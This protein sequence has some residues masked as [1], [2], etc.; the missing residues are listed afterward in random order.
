MTKFQ[1][2]IPVKENSLRLPRKNVLPFGEGNLLTHKI[3]Q[4]QN[5]AQ[6]DEIIVSTDSDEMARISEAMGC[7]VVM[8]PK[9]YADGSASFS[10]F[11][12]YL[13]SEVVRSGHLVWSCVTS[14]L[15]DEVAMKEALAAYV[16]NVIN[17]DFDSLVTVQSFRHHMFDID[18]PLNFEI[19][20]GHKD[21][22]DLVD[23]RIF[24]NG[25]VIAHTEL[26]KTWGDHFGPHAF[27]HE[28]DQ[29]KSIDIDT[30]VDYQIAVALF[31]KFFGD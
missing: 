15:F 28:V 21:S 27:Q 5:T 10:E 24:T 11:I 19:G 22:Q 25:L 29:V 3:H 9:K 23:W 26:M 8:R 12:N 30:S 18:G 6:I 20:P 7:S 16:E 2:L 4:L 1:A 17:G 13:C 14:P 31:G